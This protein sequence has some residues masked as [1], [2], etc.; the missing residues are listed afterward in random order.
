MYARAELFSNYLDFL[1]DRGHLN[2]RMVCTSGC[3]PEIQ[4]M[5]PGRAKPEP[6]VGLVS[7]DYLGFTQHPK[8]KQAAIDAVIAY[9]TGSGA[10]PA[11]GGHFSFHQQLEEAVAGFFNRDKD[12]AILYTTGY[13]SN[14]AT[15]QCLMKKED[16]AIF[17]MAVHASVQ[18]GGLL[19]NVKTFLH[20][21]LDKLE[22]VLKSAQHN[23]RTK[24][25]VID[26]VYSQDG[27]MAPVDKILALTK[28]YGAYLVIDDAH[29]IGVIGKTGRGVLE[30]Y[31]LLG[32]VDLIT[33]TFSKTFASIGGY[34]VGRPEL[35]R[36]LK[37]QSRQHLFSAAGTPADIAAIL[38][39]MI[40][41]QEEPQWMTKLWENIHYFREG[42]LNLGMDIGT[43]E[44]AIIPVKVGDPKKTGEAGRLLL[45]QGIY[46]NPIIYPA[47]SRKDARIRMSLMAT[48]TKEQLDKALKAFARVDNEIGISKHH[49]SL[50]EI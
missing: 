29:G 28:N 13:T 39:S 36:L 25:V 35:I 41:L 46:T 14:S 38:Q 26:G 3:G 16:I 44:S 12:S 10:S 4:V 33:G 42:L 27:D 40:L 1:D 8:V 21:D 5:L 32:E 11:I 24:M 49:K 23:Y 47:V 18:E 19:T 31:D 9:G 7:N 15:I 17:D 48:H 6:L 37:F 34:V 50:I 43:T 20:N 30:L 2:Y 22:H 45:E